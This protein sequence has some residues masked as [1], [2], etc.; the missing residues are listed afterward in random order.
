MLLLPPNPLRESFTW[1]VVRKNENALGVFP[2]LFNFQ[3]FLCHFWPQLLDVCDVHQLY[4]NRDSFLPEHCASHLFNIPAGPNTLCC[5]FISVCPFV[6]RKEGLP[7]FI[8][9]SKICSCLS[10]AIY[11]SIFAV[12]RFKTPM[13]WAKHVGSS[14]K[15]SVKFWS[16]PHLAF[17]F[18]HLFI[19]HLLKGFMCV[20]PVAFFDNSY[21]ADL[22]SRFRC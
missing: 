2:F 8:T 17:T 13:K 12:R 3:M 19:T 6:K 9:E 22:S 20:Y 15:V 11:F 7:V 14:V 4:G 10:C 5:S 1:K 18:S 16:L 21:L